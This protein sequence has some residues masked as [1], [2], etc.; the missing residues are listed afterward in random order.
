MSDDNTTPPEI[1]TT[2][3]KLV[4]RNRWMSVREDSIVR[5]DGQPGIYGVVEKADFACIAAMHGGKIWLVEQYRYPVGRRFWELPQGSWEDK[6][7]VDPLVLARAELQEETGLAASTMIHVARL[8]Q[9]YGYSTQA[10]NLFLASDLTQGETD[11]DAEE[12]GLIA[13]AFD[14]AEVQR[15]IVEGQIVDV[16]TVAA[17]GMLR[18][19]GLV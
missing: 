14:I 17:F 1:R 16:T 9:A 11:L 7:D 15:M 13:R 4:Y 5:P 8:F 19:K 3:S 12:Q 6:P 10:F 2:A 18:L